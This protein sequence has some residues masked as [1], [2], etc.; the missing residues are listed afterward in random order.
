[1]VNLRSAYQV[2]NNYQQDW[3]NVTHRQTLV[4]GM[5]PHNYRI[6][7]DLVRMNPN[8]QEMP[9]DAQPESLAVSK[10]RSEARKG[11]KDPDKYPPLPMSDIWHLNDRYK[12]LAASPDPDKQKQAREIMQRIGPII[13]LTGHITGVD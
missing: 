5:T 4:P 13:G 7:R 1:M 2:I 11:L 8:T 9:S 3:E 12:D 10:E 6:F